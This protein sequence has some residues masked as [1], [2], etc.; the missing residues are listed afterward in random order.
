M[1]N[2][3]AYLDKRTRQLAEMVE[4]KM[5]L[6][7]GHTQPTEVPMPHQQL[8]QP[9]PQPKFQLFEHITAEVLQ[10]FQHVT[11]ADQIIKAGKLAREGGRVQQPQGDA[12]AILD[13]A[14]KARG[15]TDED[16]Q[17]PPKGTLARAILDAG[18]K[19]VNPVR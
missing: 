8:G 19:Y 14:Q 9:S 12:K 17:L 11:A 7:V 5:A 10:Q 13:A 1:T 18:A 2:P 4:A 3:F 16:Q 6:D 15:K